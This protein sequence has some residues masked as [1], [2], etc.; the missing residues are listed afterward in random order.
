MNSIRKR[1]DSVTSWIRRKI[2]RGSNNTGQVSFPDLQ[3]DILVKIISYLDYPTRFKLR[4]NKR[5]GEFLDTI[6]NNFEGIHI[7][8]NLNNFVMSL[9]TSSRKPF[10]RFVVSNGLEHGLRRMAQNTYV[11]EIEIDA[12]GSPGG[13]AGGIYEA[14]FT[15]Q[16]DKLTIHCNRVSECVLVMPQLRLRILLDHMLSNIREAD[17]GLI[18]TSLTA[19]DLS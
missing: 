1:F 14:I 9:T 12:L 11:R 18:C 17:I 5:L 16:C 10:I 13:E 19:I 3:D 6:Q 2:L 8:I 15:F 4:L 7:Q